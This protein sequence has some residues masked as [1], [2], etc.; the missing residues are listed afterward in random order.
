M[1]R[2]AMSK[3]AKHVG[4]K[5]GGKSEKTA[6]GAPEAAAEEAGPAPEEASAGEAAATAAEETAGGAEAGAPETPEAAPAEAAAESAE[7]APEAA[8]DRLLRL[9]ADFAN[10]R[11]RMDRERHEWAVYAAEQLLKELLPVVDNFDR[12]LETCKAEESVKEGFA[13]VRQQLEGAMEKAGAKAIEDPTGQAFNPHLHEAI[14]QVPSADVPEGCVVAQTQRG[15][16]LADRLL[17]PAQVVVS[18]GPAE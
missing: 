3:H 9:Q 11:K 18:A 15:Y 5:T 10:Y 12:G 17:R 2:P 1:L 8:Q 14:A 7:D 16:V 6:K 13:L 4:G